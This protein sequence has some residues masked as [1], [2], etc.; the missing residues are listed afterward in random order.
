[1]IW[2]PGDGS[3]KM[4]GEAG[5]CIARQ[6][7]RGASTSSSPRRASASPRRATTAR[8][9]SSTSARRDARPQ[10][11]RR[12][13][14]RRRQRR[15]RADQGRRQPRRR[16]RRDPRRNDSAQVIDGA[17]G[18]DTAEVDATDS[19][20]QRRD[21]H[22]PAR[23]SRRPSRRCRLKALRVKAPAK[24][25]RQGLPGRASTSGEDRSSARRSSAPSPQAR[26]RRTKVTV[27]ITLKRSRASRWPRT[28]RSSVTVK[29][30][31][32]DAAGNNRQGDQ[33]AQPEGLALHA[34]SRT[35]GSAR[36]SWNSVP[37]GP[38]CAGP[39]R[40]AA[41]APAAPRPRRSP[42]W[43]SVIFR[44]GANAPA[45]GGRPG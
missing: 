19:G 42:P 33:A 14:R 35:P 3:D 21:R 36:A 32:T 29:V 24:V 8:R 6:R 38:G 26:R 7:R 12:R 25:N 4:D 20:Q 44:P 5:N 18:T 2:N 43:T 37:A 16:Q 9:S 11:R 34:D 45:R 27:K 1:M 10:R 40:G 13:R 31:A 22:R 17:A 28:T 15:R 30:T 41:T 39:P 23:R